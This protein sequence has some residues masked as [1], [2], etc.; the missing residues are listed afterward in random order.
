MATKINYAKA[1]FVLAVSIAALYW[2]I[3]MLTQSIFGRKNTLEISGNGGQEKSFFLF[4]VLVV[5]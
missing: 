2:P 3:S 5:L 4:I 1:K